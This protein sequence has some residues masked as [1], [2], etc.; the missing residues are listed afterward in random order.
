ML[1]VG[2]RN[3]PLSFPLEGSGDQLWAQ[4]PLNRRPTNFIGIIGLVSQ[5]NGIITPALFCMLSHVTSG[6]RIALIKKST[7]APRLMQAFFCST[8]EH[9]ASATLVIVDQW[10]WPEES[11]DRGSPLF[12]ESF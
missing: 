9:V 10:D 1:A 3:F 5:C 7:N 12:G 6:L 11:V 8:H 2:V 4:F